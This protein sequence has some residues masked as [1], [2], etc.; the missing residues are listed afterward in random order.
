VP[1]RDLRLTTGHSLYVDDVLIPVEF[2]IN[3]RSILW[4]N[5]ARVTEVCHIEL[6]SH[7]VLLAEG[8]AVESYRDGDNRRL[9]QNVDPAWDTDFAP[10]RYAPIIVKGPMLEAAWHRLAQCANATATMVTDD[11][12]LHLLVD[13][14]RVDATLHGRG[15]W[16][17]RITETPRCIQIV[18]RTGIPAALGLGPDQRRLG[19]AV[20]RIVVSEGPG[21]RI[22]VAKDTRLI[23]G[24]HDFEPAER[25]R[26]TNG[27]ATAPASLFA[28]LEGAF[29]LELQTDSTAHYA[30]AA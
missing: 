27:A 16:Q 8:A 22:V 10:P 18:S 21:M 2:L 6:P 11:P 20:R 7:E 3:H 19:V 1:H 28:D 4:D 25:W 29:T 23:E 9:F 26:W 15:V 30:A 12:D 24:F 14:A 17:F 5:A 13:G